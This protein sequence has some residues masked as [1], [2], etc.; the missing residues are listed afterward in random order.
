MSYCIRLQKADFHI[1]QEDKQRAHAA[2]MQI[3][4]SS[5]QEE[6]AD[7]IRDHDDVDT[8][9]IVVSAFG[10]RLVEDT[11]DNVVGIRY[12]GE[13]CWREEELFKALAPYVVDGS[14]V[15]VTGE[16][17]DHFRWFF[18]AGKCYQQQ[19]IISWEDLP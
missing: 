16:D 11:G 7:E 19:A 13:K 1:R 2:I 17:G 5:V 14:Y 18:T 10:W 12:E 15:E 4:N 3:G 8:L 6:I 9:A